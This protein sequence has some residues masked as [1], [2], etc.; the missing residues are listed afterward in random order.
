M[1]KLTMFRFGTLTLFSMFTLVGITSHTSALVL[2]DEQ[3]ANR[4]CTQG[5]KAVITVK[6]SNNHGSGF[7]VSQDGLIITNAHVVAGSPSVVTVVFQNG[8]QVPADVIGFARGGVDLAALKIQNRNNLPHLSLADSGTVKVGY[9]VFAI[10]TPLKVEN[11]GIC[12]QGNMSRIRLDGTI[13]HTANTYPGNSGGPLLNTQGEV[14]GV[15]TSSTSASFFDSADNKVVVTASRTGISLSQPVEKVKSFLAD[16][17]QQKI[18]SIST[19][20]INEVINN[21][22]IVY[23]KQEKWELALADF[24]KA[25]Q[26]NPQYTKAYHNR[27]NVYANQKKWELA[28]AD[29]NKAIAINSDEELAYHNRGLI[30]AKVEKWE[31]ALADFNKAIQINSQYAQAYMGRGLVYLQFNNKQKA[32]E[33]FQEAARLF[34]DQGN[35]ALYETAMGILKKL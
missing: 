29:Y 24:N 20:P 16:I 23:A 32:R 34:L 21:R 35:T 27:G 31:L 9:R 15:N 33:N 5:S 7:V 26:I 14:I 1:I 25:I 12:T 18:S 2:T 13:Q 17:R 6:N 11:R 30:Y 22:G 19:L 10:G 4:V 3:E 28:L 8:K